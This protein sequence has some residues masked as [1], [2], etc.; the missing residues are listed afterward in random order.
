[1]SWHRRTCTWLGQTKAKQAKLAIIFTKNQFYIYCLFAASL[2]SL[3]TSELYPKSIFSNVIVLFET[4]T[5][6][7]FELHDHLHGWVYE[8]ITNLAGV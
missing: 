1:M 3:A 6:Q 8:I 2:D 4:L 7:Y 5:S